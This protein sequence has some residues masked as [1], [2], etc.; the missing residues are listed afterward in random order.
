VNKDI[1]PPKARAMLITGI[2]MS[3]V[4]LLLLLFVIPLLDAPAGLT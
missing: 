3:A 2:V 1:D 4:G